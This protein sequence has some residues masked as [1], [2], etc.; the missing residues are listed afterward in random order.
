MDTRR[1]AIGTLI[2]G[3]TVFVLGYLIFD[4]AF[5][6]FYAANA[7]SAT[8]VQRDSQVVWAV[9]VGSLSY[10]TLP[11]SRLLSEPEVVPRPSEQA[12]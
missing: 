2:G 5:A 1:L 3:I 10:T 11:S 6:A 8:G 7:G 12:S 9:A 4:L